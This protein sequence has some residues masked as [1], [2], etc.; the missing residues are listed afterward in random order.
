[1]V[2]HL[3]HATYVTCSVLGIPNSDESRAF[4][5]G[6]KGLGVKVDQ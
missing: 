3:L 5:L 2:E 1:M 4:L 6:A